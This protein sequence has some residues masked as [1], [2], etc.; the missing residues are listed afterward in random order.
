MSGRSIPTFSELILPIGLALLMVFSSVL[1]Y[2]LDP[3]E[4]TETKFTSP[5]TA[6]SLVTDGSGYF[7]E[8]CSP[9][10]IPLGTD[11][12]FTCGGQGLYFYHSNTVDDVR[13]QEN[14]AQQ[15]SVGISDSTFVILDGFAYFEGNING[16]DQGLWRSNGSNV[17]TSL[18]KQI[19]SINHLTA[20]NGSLYFAGQS[21]AG[22]EPWISDGTNAGTKMAGDLVPGAG[23]SNP[24]E[25]VEFDGK[26]FMTAENETGERH[27]YWNGWTSEV[28]DETRP[29]SVTPSLGQHASI[30]SASGDN[31]IVAS[32]G[33]TNGNMELALNTGA[34]GFGPLTMSGANHMRDA[35]IV[36][37][38][39]GI[40]HISY[41]NAG[42]GDLVY[43][44]TTEW[45]NANNLVHVNLEA[46]QNTYHSS[47]DVDSYNN[48]FVVYMD[49][50]GN[51][52]RLKYRLE[53]TWYEA[54]VDGNPSFRPTIQIDDY[55]NVHINYVSSNGTLMHALSTERMN[56]FSS[57]SISE[58]AGPSTPLGAFAGPSMSINDVN[59]VGMVA[60]SVSSEE[61][62]FFRNKIVNTDTNN[63]VISMGSKHSC[64]LTDDGSVV[65]WGSQTEAF[66]VNISSSIST[67]KVVNDLEGKDTVQITST[68]MGNCA[69][70]TDGGVRCWGN[71]SGGTLGIG[72]S[73]G[74]TNSGVGVQL[75]DLGTNVSIE[76]ID[77]SKFTSCA[78]TDEGSVLCWGWNYNG[79]L[80]IGDNTGSKQKIGDAVNEMGD[81]LNYVDL[82]TNRTAKQVSV[83][84]GHT[85][86]I[87]DNDLVKCWG[88]NNNGQLGI[89][90]NGSNIGD[91]EGEMGDSLSYV[92]L[93]T[94]RTA[95]QITSGD[96]HTCAIL[97]NDL[98]KCWGT[99]NFGVLGIGGGQSTYTPSS[100]NLGAGQTANSID[101]TGQ[102][103]CVLLNNAEVRCWGRN[104]EGQLGTGSSSNSAN[105]P[106]NVEAYGHPNTRD[107][108]AIKAGDMHTCAVLEDFS[109]SCWGKN[110]DG[111][112]GIAGVSQS[113]TPL[114]PAMLGWEVIGT[115]FVNHENIPGTNTAGKHNSIAVDGE[116]VIHIAHGDIAANGNLRYSK[117]SPDAGW[118]SEIVDYTSTTGR[119]TST[120]AEENGEVHISYYDHGAEDL[121]YAH[122]DGNGWTISTVDSGGVVGLF[123]SLMVDSDGVVH[124]S[125]TDYSNMDLK[126]ARYDGNWSINTVDVAGL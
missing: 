51:K 105:S 84:G 46:V 65:C 48:P 106:Q 2:E 45:P 86:A 90:T 115:T 33:I 1:K 29:I 77:S 111:Q 79:Q 44:S 20:I 102:H 121:K 30:G 97:D 95:K 119:Y 81:D 96:D 5:H 21:S 113:P 50:A 31:I 26:V 107:V 63:S 22:I 54:L 98:V 74:S 12:L 118:S 15:I 75:I 43:L 87:L 69:L 110:G 42:S 38:S 58:I 116:G 40:M 27:I 34:S 25:F 19:S 114:T 28:I 47:I 108:V 89:Y 14:M 23:S 125:Y 9:T 78:I 99:N 124:I 3:L 8:N 91:N 11:L 57:W 76:Q 4:S 6:V 36:V 7:D 39:D 18:V 117:M 37:G 80:G 88:R 112:L 104:I 56:N 92:N 49:D 123:T 82:G 67:P 83:G 10:S 16:A 126:Y 93:G 17:G 109:L 53:S 13:T 60:T 100:V 85:C 122:H 94:G 66:G 24:Q 103:V 70:S 32:R 73:T 68:S 64:V 55:N 71:N 120:Y 62:R 52:I 41:I 72:A 35:D 59:R 61:V 101:T